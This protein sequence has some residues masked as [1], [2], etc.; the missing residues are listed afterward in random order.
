VTESSGQPT[1]LGRILPDQV[2][3]QLPTLKPWVTYSLMVLIAIFFLAHLV[4]KYAVGEEGLFLSLYRDN[5]TIHQ[6]QIWRFFTPALVHIAFLPVAFN[7]YVMYIFGKGLERFYGHL[8]LAALFLLSVFTGNVVGFI[9]AD[10]PSAGAGSGL[11]GLLAAQ[12]LFIDQNRFLFGDRSRSLVNT[13]ILFIIINLLLGLMPG[14]DTMGNLGGMVGGAIFAW[15]AGPRLTVQVAI[16]AFHL[17]DK[18]SSRRV[19]SVTLVMI[20]VLVV[21]VTFQFIIAT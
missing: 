2:A 9:A 18:I 6:G 11:M 17:V 5:E 19:V 14:M 7:L 13:A 3:I 21:L 15:L 1:P 4:L 16:P 10:I 12:T 8:R 20:S